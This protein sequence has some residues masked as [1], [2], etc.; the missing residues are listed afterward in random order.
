MLKETWDILDIFCK[1][2]SIKNNNTAVVIYG[3]GS[4]VNGEKRD[5][6]STMTDGQSVVNDTLAIARNAPCDYERERERE[7]REGE[8]VML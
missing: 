2:H 1:S 4:F 6:W 7:R 3:V 8:V 5:T